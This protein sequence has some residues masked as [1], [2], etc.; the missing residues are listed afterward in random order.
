MEID[1]RPPAGSGGSGEARSPTGRPAGAERRYRIHADRQ[2]SQRRMA[3]AQWRRRRSV[4]AG[5]LVP[6]RCSS[7]SSRRC[8]SRPA[9][10]LLSPCR[11]ADRQQSRAPVMDRTVRP[12]RAERGPAPRGIR[13]AARPGTSGDGGGR[14]SLALGLSRRVQRAGVSLLGSGDRELAPGSR[15]YRGRCYSPASARGTEWAAVR[16]RMD[17]NRSSGAGSPDLVRLGPAMG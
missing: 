14:R 11:A 10:G 12:T 4:A 2:R 17:R 13:T 15:R 3:M 8:L 7:F 9:G 1:G 5:R 16:L 6:Q